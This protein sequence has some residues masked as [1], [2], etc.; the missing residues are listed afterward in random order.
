MD[1]FW[2]PSHF[3]RSLGR[4]IA[5]VPTSGE[6]CGA[7]ELCSSDSRLSTGSAPEAATSMEEIRPSV[8][9]PDNRKAAT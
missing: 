6:F 3:L 7:L 1:C 8:G 9:W 5:D 2:G 4:L